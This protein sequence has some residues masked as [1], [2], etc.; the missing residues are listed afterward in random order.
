M[1]KKKKPKLDPPGRW[2]EFVRFLVDSNRGTPLK[3]LLKN[4][5]PQDYTKF[6]KKFPVKYS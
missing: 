4:Y 3:K 6:C 5:T 1:T 2:K